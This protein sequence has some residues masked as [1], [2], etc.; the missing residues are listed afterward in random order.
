LFNVRKYGFFEILRINAE[1]RWVA[2]FMPVVRVCLGYLLTITSWAFISSLRAIARLLRKNAEKGSR[3]GSEP[4]NPYSAHDA[5]IA[6]ASLNLTRFKEIWAEVAPT[7][8]ATNNDAAIMFRA[9]AHLLEPSV[10]ALD[11]ESRGGYLA[12]PA[13]VNTQIE[14][15]ST[16]FPEDLAPLFQV[17][18]KICLEIRPDQ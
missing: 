16:R 6:S 8:A 12:V 15:L 11:A 13:A 2:P 1:S 14:Q 5:M 9:I 18:A 7:Y 3:D 17:L 4:A 10:S